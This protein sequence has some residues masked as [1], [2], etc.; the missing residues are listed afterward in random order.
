MSNTDLIDNLARNKIIQTRRVYDGM[1]Q[2]DR[3]LFMAG[4]VHPVV[5]YQDAPQSIGE[6]TRRVALQVEA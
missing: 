1:M 4:Q 6:S 5:A 3:R 2:V